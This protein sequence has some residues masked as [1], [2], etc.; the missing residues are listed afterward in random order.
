MK[1]KIGVIIA[2]IA[3]AVGASACSSSSPS[4][5]KPV[6]SDGSSSGGSSSSGA[7]TD[8]VK[9]FVNS[10]LADMQSLYGDLQTFAD[11]T[12]QSNIDLFAVRAD[13]QLL[14]ADAQTLQ[15][16]GSINDPQAEGAWSSALANIVSGGQACV[17]GIDT[18]NTDLITQAT[19]DFYN[20]SKAFDEIGVN[21]A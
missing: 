3:I 10:N 19:T 18:N 4:A 11:D 12:S 8:P 2:T 6:Q 16:D 20:A 21:N 13:C 17:S 14:T 7:T 9:A 5:S 1:T 15:G